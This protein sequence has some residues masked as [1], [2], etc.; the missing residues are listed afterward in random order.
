MYPEEFQGDVRYWG[1][2][3]EVTDITEDFMKILFKYSIPYKIDNESIYIY[4]YS[5][6]PGALSTPSNEC[7]V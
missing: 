3:P 7:T 4:G 2:A 6:S 5:A 1:V